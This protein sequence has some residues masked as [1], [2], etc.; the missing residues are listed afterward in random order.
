LSFA[1]RCVASGWRLRMPLWRRRRWQAV[2][3]D[4][5]TLLQCTC[6][7]RSD[8]CNATADLSF[9]FSTKCAMNRKHRWSGFSVLSF[10]ILK[11]GGRGGVC[12]WWL[13]LPCRYSL[14]YV[15]CSR[16][17]SVHCFLVFQ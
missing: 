17:V 13:R 7:R 15:N 16:Y 10:V 6:R 2:V 5:A 11:R 4:Q 8:K 14:R 12:C 1:H 3:W 9:P